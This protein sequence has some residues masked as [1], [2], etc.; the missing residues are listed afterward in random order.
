MSF[1]FDGLK[2][3]GI[4]LDV[5]K[6]LSKAQAV[7]VVGPLIGSPVKALVSLIELVVG[8]IF[9]VVLG[10]VS[11]LG[12]C[13]S[14][15]FANEAGKGAFTAGTHAL[16]GLWGIGYSAANFLTLGILGFVI[17]EPFNKATWVKA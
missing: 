6:G 12:C 7:P 1:G 14:N 16:L 2:G 3:P 8:F 10:I 13:C 4:M 17:E 5:Q 9:A 15:N 11:V